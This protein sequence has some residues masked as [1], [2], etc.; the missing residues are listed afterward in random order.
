MVQISVSKLQAVISCLFLLP[1]QGQRGVHTQANT[2]RVKH[3][4]TNKHPAASAGSNTP[5]NIVSVPK[6]ES[7]S[8]GRKTDSWG[9]TDSVRERQN[10]GNSLDLNILQIKAD[11]ECTCRHRCRE[12]EK[13]L[14][15]T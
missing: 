13:N 3:M 6:S 5:L 1:K 7:I 11:T 10:R 15:Y 4:H 8:G 9:E 2:Y 12:E 14:I